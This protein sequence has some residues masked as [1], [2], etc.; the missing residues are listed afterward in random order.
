MGLPSS[1]SRY[2]QQ[3]ERKAR[4][5][6]FFMRTM[7]PSLIL[8]PIVT[9]ACLV[10][11]PQISAMVLQG[12]SH[13]LLAAVVALAIVPE[14]LLRHVRGGFSGMRMF[15]VTSAMDFFPVLIS[16]L[17]G[18]AFVMLIARDPVAAASAQVIGSWVS[19]AVFGGLLW[20][21]LRRAEPEHLKIEEPDFTSKILKF[22][23]WSMFMPLQMQLLMLVDRWILVRL[24]GLHD[25][26]I[27][28]AAASVSA[29][30]FL[31]GQLTANVL[32]PNLSQMWEEGDRGMV[33]RRIN[34][35][36]RV[37]LLGLLGVAL[38][39]L[40]VSP[41]VIRVICGRG[42][43]QSADLIWAF[44]IYNLF[45]SAFYVVNLYP[46][47]IEKPQM[48]LFAISAGLV[49]DVGLNLILIPRFGLQ[50]AATA[51]FTSM[52]VIVVVLLVAC[53]R[54]GFRVELRTLFVMALLFLP[55]LRSREL[56]LA[57]YAALIVV[58]VFT[59]WV[60]ARDEKA[61]LR[62]RVVGMLRWRRA[63]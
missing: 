33:M 26:G 17:L 49:S 10:L 57:V 7:R 52:A 21:H 25:V 34:F 13:V 15:A 53:V 58:V 44:V 47:L 9:I 43:L 48:G 36:L 24:R 12:R 56:L 41:W 54:A 59:P 11:A 1:Y 16:S 42:F 51:A 29:Y 18:V 38:F 5:R 63:A 31:L 61:M 23:S 40:A 46:T 32:S 60:L 3:Y 2:V 35:A 14:A 28:S 4:L 6:D 62:E 50:G 19:L 55:T 45:F 22:S 37:T 39:L 30:V 20:R 27:Y 8:A